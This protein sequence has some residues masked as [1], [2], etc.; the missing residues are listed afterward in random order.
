MSLAPETISLIIGISS[1]IISIIFFFSARCSET[2]TIELL[3]QIDERVSTLKSI[4]DNLLGTAIKY[5]T[6]S[7]EQLINRIPTQ[8]NDSDIIS[9][10]LKTEQFNS[11]DLV[12]LIALYFYTARA[13][14]FANIVK[15]S[16]P[17]TDKTKHIHVLADDTIKNSIEDFLNL[18]EAFKHQDQNSMRKHKLYHIYIDL[19]KYWKQYIAQQ[20]N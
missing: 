4:N 6:R 10:L 8:N 9:H 7:N 18:S 11:D 17:L 15:E 2:H 14:Y 1:F 20:I 5:L 12:K 16:I 19:E 3:S 13:N